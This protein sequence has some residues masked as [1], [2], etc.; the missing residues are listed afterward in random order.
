M[1]HAQNAE[2]RRD[3]VYDRLRQ[4]IA[5]GR[6]EPGKKL[7][8]QGLAEA[9]G[10]SRTP[11][12]EALSQLMNDGLLVGLGRGYTIPDLTPQDV[13]HIYELRLLIEPA[14]AQQTASHARHQDVQSL[15]AALNRELAN[16]TL[17]DPGPFIAANLDYRAALIAPCPNTRLASWASLLNDQI[18]RVMHLTLGPADNRETTVSFHRAA[19]EG[20]RDG[21]GDRAASGITELLYRARDNFRTMVANDQWGGV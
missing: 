3:T 7:S 15:E 14:I 16:A 18:C 1:R 8:E 10:V 6:L 4:D 2:N 21:D 13:E 11:V 12:R 19:Y 17:A 5:Q 9:L 20:I